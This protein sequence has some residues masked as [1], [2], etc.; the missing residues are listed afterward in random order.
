LVAVGGEAPYQFPP[1]DWNR[2]RA[3]RDASGVSSQLTASDLK[4]H[5]A[6]LAMELRDSPA[7][8]TGPRE[9]RL[10]KILVQ[11]LCGE[12][13]MAVALEEPYTSTTLTPG[14]LLRAESLTP[15]SSWKEW[16]TGGTQV[17]LMLG[18]DAES[19]DKPFLAS[20]AQ[21]EFAAAVA[22]LSLGQF[23][24]VRVEI[25]L[26]HV[27]EDVWLKVVR[28]ERDDYG[29]HHLICELPADLQLY[30]SWKSGESCNVSFWQVRETKLPGGK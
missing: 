26:G 25:K 5:T 21:R 4:M 30:P 3:S 19:A 14:S 27:S 10:A 6:W 16:L 7:A 9:D 18:T 1:E 17:W 22:K 13:L 8:I 23:A 11:K 12:N 20:K 24:Q 29:G 28:M 2:I 15:E